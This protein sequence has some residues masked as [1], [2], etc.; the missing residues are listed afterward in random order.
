M[1]RER[2]CVARKG[3]AFP[4]PPGVLQLG[5]HPFVDLRRTVDCPG[6]SAKASPPIPQAWSAK[7]R[8]LTIAWGYSE[9]LDVIDA[10][11]G[12]RQPGP[13][14]RT[15]GAKAR[16][17]CGG[18]RA[19]SGASSGRASTG[20]AAINATLTAALVP[21]EA[22][23]RRPQKMSIS[24]AWSSGTPMN[25]SRGF[26]QRMPIVGT[27]HPSAIALRNSRRRSLTAGRLA[28]RSKARICTSAIG[29]T[30]MFSFPAELGK[31]GVRQPPKSLIRIGATLL[32]I[33][34]GS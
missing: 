14:P 19:S 15:A 7:S 5:N 9:N 10:A 26:Q 6:K 16:S 12:R 29:Q 25:C 22:P 13:A 3:G 28:S 4:R 8:G 2:G 32:M 20:R 30:A 21:V 33:R 34:T 23:G 31:P 18:R 11:I 17:R 1:R 27:A 24:S